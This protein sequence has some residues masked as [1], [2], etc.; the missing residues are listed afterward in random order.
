MRCGNIK[1]GSHIFFG[2]VILL[3][4]RNF[5]ICTKL[6]YFLQYIYFFGI[7]T[8]SST[9]ALAAFLLLGDRW[10]LCLFM[11][12]HFRYKHIQELFDIYS[13]YWRSFTTMMFKRKNIFFK[14]LITN[15]Q[16]CGCRQF[17]LIDQLGFVCLIIFYYPV[18]ALSSSI[19]AA[20]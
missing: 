19:Q 6:L 7:F 2:N 11:L 4:W 20:R 5:R 8:N 14:M 1:L 17:F 16:F 13:K 12:V 18:Q 3:I 9:V 15:S 10:C